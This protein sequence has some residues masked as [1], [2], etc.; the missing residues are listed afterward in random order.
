MNSDA[1]RLSDRVMSSLERIVDN[2]KERMRQVFLNP[3]K[4][5]VRSYWI[6]IIIFKL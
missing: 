4:V 2:F 5:E 3:G 1:I 6:E